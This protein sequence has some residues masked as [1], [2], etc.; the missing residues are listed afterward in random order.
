M[1][2]NVYSLYSAFCTQPAF[3]SQ[4][5]VCILHSVCI[6][7]LV[8][9]LQSAVRSLRFTLTGN[10]IEEFLLQANNFHPTV[11]F[12][13]GW[14]IRNRDYILGHERYEGF[15]FNKD[16]ILE[17]RTHFKPTETFQ[18]TNQLYSRHP[19]GVT[20]G[21][22]TFEENMRNFSTR[23]KNG[24]YPANTVEKHLSEVILADRKKALEL[25]SAIP[26][27]VAQP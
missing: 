1:F 7:P 2:K 3:Y 24:D 4:S 18:Y 16:S 26:P 27:C 15:R 19:P 12:T 9:S 23:L 14:N 20:K 21:F 17:V 10:E 13:H 22:I 11:K 8:R 6:L 5:A 25:C